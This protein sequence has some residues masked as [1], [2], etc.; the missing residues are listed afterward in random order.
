MSS[1]VGN[2]EDAADDL[3]PQLV[4]CAPSFQREHIGRQRSSP[5]LLQAAKLESNALENCTNK[6][7]A[8][9]LG[10][11]SHEGAGRAAASG[12]AFSHEKRKEEKVMG[13]RWCRP[14]R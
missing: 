14:G 3:A 12:A 9:M 7:T 1:S 10:C 11:Q 5:L 4:L 8:V 6:I 2:S 13:A